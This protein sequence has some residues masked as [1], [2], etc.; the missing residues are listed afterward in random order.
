MTD[1]SEHLCTCFAADQLAKELMTKT[2]ENFGAMYGNVF[3]LGGSVA[4]SR[5]ED[6]CGD[7]KLPGVTGKNSVPDAFGISV[8]ELL[9]S[10]ALLDSNKKLLGWR[11]VHSHA[12][13]EMFTRYI[14][15]RDKIRQ[16]RIEKRGAAAAEA[17]GFVRT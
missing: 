4:V 7:W 8:S 10:S 11:P 6:S 15:R 1:E 13:K 5:V 16:E 12:A 17:N 14:V 9:V 3:F 2:C